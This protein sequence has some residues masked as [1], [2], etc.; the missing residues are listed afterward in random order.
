MSGF[1]IDRAFEQLCL[2][3]QQKTSPTTLSPSST[4]FSEGSSLPFEKLIEDKAGVVTTVSDKDRLTKDYA[5]AWTDFYPSKAGCVYKSGPAWEV[6]EG[7]EEQ[8]IRREARTVCRPD[9][10]LVWPAML[11]KI[12]DCLDNLG[13]SLTCVNPFA[14]ANEGDKKP[15]CPLLSVGV[16]PKSLTYQLARSAAEAVK[17]ILASINLADVE[18]AFQEME[19]SCSAGGLPLLSLNPVAD[20]VP[21]YRK[22]FS[23]RLGV[24]IAPLSAPS[25]EGTGGLYLTCAHVVRPLPVFRTN[26][27]MKRVNKS[28]GKEYM[29]ALGAGGYSRV[30]GDMMAQIAKLTRDISTFNSQLNLP[31]ISAAKHAEKAEITKLTATRGH[32]DALH[33]EVTKFRSTPELRI[34]G[35]ALYSSPIAV[36]AKVG[37]IG[38]TKDWAFVQID[39]KMLD[40]ATFE[41]NKL[42]FGTSFPPFFVP[43]FRCPLFRRAFLL[44]PFPSPLLL[45]PPLANLR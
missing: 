44:P 15:F 13:V 7:P 45:P 9:I 32:L 16:K 26:S 14:W 34:F 23:A 29:V 33:T 27:G 12:I 39:P 24:P 6:R 43:P 11:K 25:L 3:F 18:V 38:Y 2:N 37:E 8:G 20:D 1:Q 28:Q 10:A 5:N 19:V 35:W 22:A 40:L 17:K 21:E 41:G 4:L 31:H 42:Y 36:D 30:V